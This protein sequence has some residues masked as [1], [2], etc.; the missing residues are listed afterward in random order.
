MI[1]DIQAADSA[2]A[3]PTTGDCQDSTNDDDPPFKDFTLTELNTCATSGGAPAVNVAGWSSS[4]S[5]NW[6]GT[7]PTAEQ[8]AEET[9]SWDDADPTTGTIWPYLCRVNMGHAEEFLNVKVLGLYNPDTCT[10]YSNG[11]PSVFSVWAMWASLFVWASI[12]L[13]IFNGV[14]SSSWV[15]WILSLI[16]I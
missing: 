2:W 8:Q 15:V 1:S 12:F 16:H 7:C 3:L 10:A 9:F 4:L 6:E 13:A 11:D 5:S 14:K